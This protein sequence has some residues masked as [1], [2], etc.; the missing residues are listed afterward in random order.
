MSTSNGYA[1]RY[2]CLHASDLAAFA[3]RHK[4]RPRDECLLQY[5][6]TICPAAYKRQDRLLR[7]DQSKALLEKVIADVPSIA[8]TIQDATAVCANEASTNADA[9]MAAEQTVSII[10]TMLDTT[11]HGDDDKNLLKEHCRSK[12]YTEF[13]THKEASVTDVVRQSHHAANITK[14]DVY[15]KR[16]LFDLSLGSDDNSSNKINVRVFIGGKCDGIM[17]HKENSTVKIVE[18]KNRMKRLFKSVP[19]YERVQVLAYLFIHDLREAVLIENYNGQTQEH[20][21]EFDDEYWNRIVSDVR[22]GVA[23]IFDMIS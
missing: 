1:L 6:K 19:E 9:Y 10:E 23:E 16:A 12:I 4:Y 17:T 8:A 22:R 3:G 20:A 14:D 11:L 15:R 21:I 13:G 7:D 18:I 5:L 2:V